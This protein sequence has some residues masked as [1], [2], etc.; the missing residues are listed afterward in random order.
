MRLIRPCKYADVGENYFHRDD[1]E[2]PYAVVIKKSATLNADFTWRALT[3]D[4]MMIS[5][6]E[7]LYL[8]DWYITREHYW[9][10][11]DVVYATTD[12]D[13]TADDVHALVNEQ[14]N[15]RRL[16]IDKAKAVRAMSQQLGSRAPRERIP[17]TVKIAVWQRDGGRC[18]ECAG[19]RDLEFDHIIPLAMGGSNTERN[20]QLLCADCNRRKGATLG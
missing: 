2:R 11:A 10:Y 14:A 16:Q 5:R 6:V 20:L 9:L 17:H 1:D 12:P 13:L 7:P 8:G 3:H 4:A 18:V 15:R 19:N